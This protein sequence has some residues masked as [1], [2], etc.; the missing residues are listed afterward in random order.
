MAERY[1]GIAKEIRQKIE[2][3]SY[4]PGTLIPPRLELAKSFGVARATIDRCIEHLIASG[5]LTSRQ[6][7]G[8]YVSNS[9][10]EIRK[11]AFIGWDQIPYEAD[12]YSGMTFINYEKLHDKSARNGLLKYDG[13]LLFRPDEEAIEWA[14]ELKEK[15][16]LV[17]VNR[18]EDGFNC[19]STDHRGAFREITAER[20]E[21]LPQLTP[22]FLRHHE[23]GNMVSRYRESGF[24]DAC[25]EKG[26]FYEK[27]YMPENMDSKIRVLKRQIFESAKAPFFIVS[28]SMQHCGALVFCVRDSGLQW[29]KDIFYSDIDNDMPEYVWGLSITSYIQDD[30]KILRDSISMLLKVIEEG[31]SEPQQILVFPLRKN[32]MS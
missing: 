20:L 29:Q 21:Q 16:P 17:L 15:I 3:G 2:D 14:R 10:S 4:P 18:V 19:V 22:Y 12:L 8:T 9:V 13:L 24:V 27:I 6:G 31:I 7:S 25:R 5:V 30:R 11:I 1:I 32:G 28:D 23:E 26:R